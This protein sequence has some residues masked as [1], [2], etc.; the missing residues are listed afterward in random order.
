MQEE[1]F[2]TLEHVPE[3]HNAFM[4]FVRPLIIAKQEEL[5]KSPFAEAAPKVGEF[6][7]VPDD[8]L[9]AAVAEANEESK[10]AGGKKKK[11]NKKKKKPAADSKTDAA[12]APDADN[13]T[14]AAATL[15]QPEESKDALPEKIEKK[16][17]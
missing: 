4:A 13:T 8:G 7:T 10:G 9:E 14:P 6:E 11:K 17:V 12:E 16:D 1:I 2:H 3:D 15:N 5:S